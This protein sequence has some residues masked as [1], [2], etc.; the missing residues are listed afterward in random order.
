MKQPTLGSRDIKSDRGMNYD[1]DLAQVLCQLASGNLEAD[2]WIAWWANNA[3]RVA[4]RIKRVQYLRLKPP[5]PGNFGPA[6]RCASI[7]QVEACKLLDDWGVTYVISDRYRSEWLSHFEADS[8]QEDAKG[9]E[10]QKQ[11]KPIIKT[12]ESDFPKFARFL[13]RNMDTIELIA[14]PASDD[15][16]A[17][18]ESDLDVILPDMYKRFLQCCKA[19]ELG[20]T[21]KIGLPYTTIHEFRRGKKLPTQ[22]MLCFGDCWLEA[23]GD[24][25]FF[26]DSSCDPP[27]MYYAHEVP[28]LREV[29]SSFVDWIESISK[30]IS[31]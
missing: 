27:I 14:V 16:I 28:Q 17:A 30:W 8:K 18:C 11:F 19:I 21:L 1:P 29:G 31:C 23:D 12:L 13:R 26:G 5:K 9:K 25:V 2:E 24:Y 15:E 20:D 7:S 3:D 4:D 10:R 22:S 6:C